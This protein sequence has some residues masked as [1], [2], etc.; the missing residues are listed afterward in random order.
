MTSLPRLRHGVPL[1]LLLLTVTLAGCGFFD[2]GAYARKAA[3]KLAAALSKRDVSAIP[4]TAGS[5]VRSYAAMAKT[6]D[7]PTKVTVDQVTRSG[8]SADVRLNWVVDLDGH[9]WKHQTHAKLLDQAHTWIGHQLDADRKGRKQA[10]D[11]A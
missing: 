7:Y 8:D 11:A 2:K 1:L 3:D 9:T 4:F 5:A 6:L 10:Q